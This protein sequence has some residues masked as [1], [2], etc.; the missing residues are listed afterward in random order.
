MKTWPSAAKEGLNDV[1]SP[2]HHT[3]S[4]PLIELLLLADV[5]KSFLLVG[6]ILWLLVVSVENWCRGY[7]YDAS[8]KFR[9]LS[10]LRAI[11]FQVIIPRES[12]RRLDM[13]SRHLGIWGFS[14][15]DHIIRDRSY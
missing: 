13:W 4:M 3:T 6:I 5:M 7:A 1:R 14:T 8:E 11:S 2:S 12:P 15:S 10:L 9:A